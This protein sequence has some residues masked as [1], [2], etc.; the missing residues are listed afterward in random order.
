M[1][2]TFA[3]GFVKGARH[4]ERAERGTTLVELMVAVAVFIVIS[5]VAF[6]LL[7]SQQNA[8]IG[9]N[10]RV[11]LN[12]ALRN[13]A[14]MLQ[15]D[16]ANAGN[17]YY[18]A[19]QATNMA[20][21]GLG[22]TLTNNVVAATSGSGCYTAPTGSAALGT[23]GANCF[24]Q[25]N[26]IQV[27][28][29]YPVLTATDSTGGTGIG[30]NC[31]LTS[32]G[33]A[34]GNASAALA[35]NPYKIGDQLLFVQNSTATP[36][37]YTSVVLTQIPT[38][39]GSLVYFTFQPT[40]STTNSNGTFNGVNTV[41]VNDPLNITTCSGVTP[42]PPNSVPAANVLLTNKFCAGGSATQ[43]DWIIKLAPV[44]YHVQSLTDYA[45]NQNPTL[46]RTQ[47]GVTTNVMEQVIGFKVGGT[48]WNDPTTSPDQSAYNYDA[49]SYTLNPGSTGANNGANAYEFTLLRSIRVSLI[50]RTA[51]VY[52]QNYTYR[53][54]F[55]QGPYQIQGTVVVVNPRNMNF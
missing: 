32:S 21:G 33:H 11:G 45:G 18:Q 9:A 19:T 46:T 35:S 12:M 44:T 22:V 53:N 15:M 38:V 4:W 23:Y 48:I 3:T 1:N 40:I 13:T 31:S 39:T 26:I 7:N 41:G 14:S 25:L 52:T 30:L 20:V 17:G 43:G 6:S 51:P 5:T 8:S 16:L 2:K 42:C 34:Y 27:D 37:Q 10:G 55:D 29:T 24:D 54:T 50:G 36:Q 28:S 47:G 49:S